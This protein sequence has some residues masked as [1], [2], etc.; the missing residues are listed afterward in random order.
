MLTCHFWS[1]TDGTNV[2]PLCACILPSFHIIFCLVDSLLACATQT[3]VSQ[4][5]IISVCPIGV[6]NDEHSII[7]SLSCLYKNYWH[8]SNSLLYHASDSK[9]V[10]LSFIFRDG[11]E[12]YLSRSTV[13]NL[14]EHHFWATRKFGK[15]YSTEFHINTGQISNIAVASRTIFLSFSDLYS[16]L[17]EKL[18]QRNQ[19]NFIY[20]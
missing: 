1:F 18:F 7:Q 3:L 16:S 17:K 20:G 19:W 14:V 2:I 5:H 10:N 12:C 13:V 15:L 8:P 9:I 4:S 11:F 6:V